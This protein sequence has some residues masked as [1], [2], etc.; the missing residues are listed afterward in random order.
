MIFQ[1]DNNRIIV[2]NG[3]KIYIINI[4]E[5][6]ITSTESIDENVNLNSMCL[7]GNKKTIIGTCNEGKLLCYNTETKEINC[8]FIGS[9]SG[10][11]CLIDEH[12][13]I[14]SEEIKIWKS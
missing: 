11:V 8:L 7:L 14:T 13:F 1:I 4:N 2:G 9:S 10:N 3:A 12:I 5:M 6:V